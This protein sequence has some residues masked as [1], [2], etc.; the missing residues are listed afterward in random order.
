MTTLRSK[1]WLITGVVFVVAAVM[2]M[3]AMGSTTRREVREISLVAR[4]MAFYTDGGTAPNPVLYARPGERLRITVTNDA[5]GMIHDF[6]IDA[7]AASTSTLIAG[8]VAS[9]EITVPAK[10]GE[11]EYRCRPHALMMKG[12]LKVLPQ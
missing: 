12:V 10:A 8:Q 5:P 2:A 6:A 9:I 4:S 11:Y 1:I 3:A 7:L